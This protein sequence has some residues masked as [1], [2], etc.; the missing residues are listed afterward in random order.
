MSNDNSIDIEKNSDAGR[1]AI[2]D[3]RVEF[4]MFAFGLA[5]AQLTVTAAE[6]RAEKLEYRDYVAFGARL[7]RAA[8]PLPES[9]SNVFQAEFCRLA[10]SMGLHGPGSLELWRFLPE[11]GIAAFLADRE[12]LSPPQ[13]TVWAAIV[14]QILEFKI[15]DRP[16]VIK[17]FMGNTRAEAI[18]GARRFC[19]GR[20]EPEDGDEESIFLEGT[21]VA[22]QKMLPLAVEHADW[23]GADLGK[24]NGADGVTLGFTTLTMDVE[25]RTAQQVSRGV[26][27]PP[28]PPSLASAGGGGARARLP[29][30]LPPRGGTSTRR[31][32]SSSGWLGRRTTRTPPPHAAR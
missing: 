21:I 9:V 29:R 31:P 8:L 27:P 12:G 5:G 3:A 14:D 30:W 11:D 16:R 22:L 23:L 19:R 32:G 4:R 26:P 1:R 2:A 24:R 6:A 7:G 15:F 28:P 25:D 13:R 20:L 10:R 17:S 18:E